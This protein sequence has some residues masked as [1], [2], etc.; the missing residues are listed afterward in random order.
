M[1]N[2]TFLGCLFVGCFDFSAYGCA[3]DPGQNCLAYAGCDALVTTH[4]SAEDWFQMAK[5]IDEACSEDS[6]VTSSGRSK[7]QL[8]CEDK[9]CCFESGGEYQSGI[10]SYLLLQPY[11]FIVSLRVSS[12]SS[13]CSFTFPLIRVRVCRR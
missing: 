12:H 1:L 10:R 13:S 7:C 8:M 6:L 3:N 5:D 9:L 2:L 11:C 4:K